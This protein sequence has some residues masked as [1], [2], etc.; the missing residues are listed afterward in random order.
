MKFNN[1]KK[2]NVSNFYTRAC[3]FSVSCLTWLICLF[4]ISPSFAQIKYDNISISA[5]RLSRN[6]EK[7]V[8]EVSGNIQIVAEGKHFQGE[9]ATIYTE[10]NTIEVQ[11]NVRITTPTATIV[12]KRVIM[13]YKTS[14][15]TI[16]DGYVESSNVVF[17]GKVIQKLDKDR[18]TLNDGDYTTCTTCPASW[19]ITGSHIKARVGEYA[20]ITYPILRIG[21]LPLLPL[22]YIVVP[23]KTRRQTGFLSPTFGFSGDGVVFSQ[24][25]FWA[26]ARNQDSTW[27]FI[28]HPRRTRYLLEYRYLLSNGGYGKLNYNHVIENFL[29]QT[30]DYFNMYRPEKDHF[31]STKRW[32]FKYKHHDSFFSDYLY[33]VNIDL[34]SD[35]RYSRDFF[36]ETKTNGYPALDNRIS[37]TKNSLTQHFS[38]DSSYY[39]NLLQANPYGDNAD[40]VHRLP[41]I[42]YSTVSQKVAG[43]NLRFKFDFNYVNFTRAH[44]GYDDITELNTQGDIINAKTSMKKI[45]DA[46]EKK[47]VVRFP[48]NNA[49]KNPLTCDNFDPN[50]TDVR[51]GKFD[52]WDIIR[53]GQRMNFAPSLSYPLHLSEYIDLMPSLTFNYT[54][55]K[56]GVETQNRYERSNLRL[57]LS[58]RTTLSRVFTLNKAKMDDSDTFLKEMKQT[59]KLIANAVGEVFSKQKSSF[60]EIP[61]SV[62]RYKHEIQPEITVTTLPIVQ[63][64]GH[65]FFNINKENAETPFFRA[66]E[67]I[68]NQDLFSDRRLQFD[69]FDRLY[70]RELITLAINNKLTRRTWTP[71]GPKYKQFAKL[72][73]S[74]TFDAFEAR[75]ANSRPWSTLKALVEVRMNKFETV[76]EISYFPYH[77]VVNFDSRLRF[78]LNAPQNYLEFFINRKFQIGDELDIPY[79]TRTEDYTT[80]FVRSWKYLNFSANFVYNQVRNEIKSWK[81]NTLLKFPGDCWAVLLSMN[82]SQNQLDPPE[83]N[84][85]FQFHFDGQ[86]PSSFKNSTSAAIF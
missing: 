73:V 82:D 34:A 8:I 23:L 47:V 39:I 17:A 25:F 7:K 41:E 30:H 19:S 12:A 20:Q 36:E 13:N 79:D 59:S 21:G 61:N 53:T 70:D 71:N 68:S 28:N 83:F 55:Y 80:T 31:T 42:N 48:T 44:Y 35:L 69:S 24:S 72:R 74:Q 27:T 16:Y 37:V 33:H 40:A 38:I 50:C 11:G 78:K 43:S 15:G 18:Y 66:N 63:D 62:T 81:A 5:D 64:K 2:S 6:I 49:K 22:P 85:S 4:S 56:F 75:Q 77:R 60:D 52:P 65:P 54:Q 76:S 67:S 1:M 26:M 3:H 32:Y 10:S 46:Q 14:V 58:A 51:D 29:T 84:F 45:F 57:S 9:I 86:K